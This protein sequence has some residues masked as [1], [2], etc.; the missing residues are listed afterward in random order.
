MRVVL[1]TRERTLSIGSTG[2]LYGFGLLCVQN[3]HEIAFRRS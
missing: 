2:I 1:L 3:V